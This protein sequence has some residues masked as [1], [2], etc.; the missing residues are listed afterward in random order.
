MRF[1]GNELDQAK[2]YIKELK[3]KVVTARYKG[4]SLP[5]TTE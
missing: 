2:Y 4:D 5:R 3:L 1:P